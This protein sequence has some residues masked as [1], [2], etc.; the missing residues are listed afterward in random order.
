MIHYENKAIKNPRWWGMPG[1]GASRG[2]NSDQPP[3]SHG[4][5]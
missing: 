5:A 3:R 4:S 1:K 2:G